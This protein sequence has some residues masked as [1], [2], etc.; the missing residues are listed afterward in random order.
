MA[1]HDDVRANRLALDA[2]EA[3]IAAK[4][5][6]LN[7]LQDQ[8]MQLKNQEDVINKAMLQAVHAGLASG[9]TFAEIGAELDAANAEP[10]PE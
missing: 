7:E 9:K 1:L 3:A 6:E 4:A 8:R 2:V 5:A 10:D